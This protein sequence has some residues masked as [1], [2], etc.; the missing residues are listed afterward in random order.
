MRRR[1]MRSSAVPSEYSE[2]FAINA[3]GSPAVQVWIWCCTRMENDAV[4]QCGS[5]PEKMTEAVTASV[6]IVSEV[7]Y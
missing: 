4:S 7:M 5:S 3:P 2:Q 6:P 1:G